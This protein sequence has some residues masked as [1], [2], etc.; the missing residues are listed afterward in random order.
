MVEILKMQEHISGDRQG[1]LECIFCRSKKLPMHSQDTYI[2][3]IPR[4]CASLRPRN[5][6]H[7]VHKKGAFQVVESPKKT[8]CSTVLLKWLFLWRSEP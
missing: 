7:P 1:W 2:L 5:T 4:S 3:Y 8:A 6:V